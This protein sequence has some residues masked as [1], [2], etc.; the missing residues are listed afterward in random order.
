MEESGDE[1]E[2]EEG[3]IIR[4]E[5]RRRRT[6]RRE[7]ERY[8]IINWQEGFK[9]EE[10]GYEDLEVWAVV[11]FKASEEDANGTEPGKEEEKE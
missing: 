7:E 2:E 6:G 10:E 8:G 5:G 4:K 9:G 3:R 11:E 1:Q